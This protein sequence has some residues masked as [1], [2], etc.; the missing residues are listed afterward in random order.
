MPNF[1]KSGFR[2]HEIENF[3]RG[4][5]PEP[6]GVLLEASYNG[7]R[8]ITVTVCLFH[9]Q[10]IIKGSVERSLLPGTVFLIFRE[11]QA[12]KS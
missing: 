1:K 4:R 8:K 10:E 12:L 5:S 6:P 11:K 2:P 3:S 7:S 9:A